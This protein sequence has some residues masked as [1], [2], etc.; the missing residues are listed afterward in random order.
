MINKCFKRENSSDIEL[1]N[2]SILPESVVI[3]SLYF[4]LKVSQFL[5]GT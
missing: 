5:L 1:A 3:V 4:F 2:L